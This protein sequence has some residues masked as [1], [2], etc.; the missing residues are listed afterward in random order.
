MKREVNR[1][2]IE[3][4]QRQIHALETTHTPPEPLLGIGLGALESAFPDQVFPRG[5]IHELIST[6]SEEATCTSGFMA[7]LLEKFLKQGGFCLWISTKPRRSIF[8]PALKVFGVEPDRI[9]F[10]DAARPK[11]TLWVLEEALKCDALTA[12]VG[13]L[14]ELSFN[15]S[16][17]LQLAVER[18]HVTGFI[19]RFQ[20]KTQNSVACVSRWKIT[21]IASTTPNGMPGVGFPAWNVELLKVKNGQPGKWQV[22]WSPKGLEY[23]DRETTAIPETYERQIG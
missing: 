9:L 6:S 1:K 5:V 20:P 2:I 15:E 4:L 16:R 10:V 19:H 7:I 17:R 12:V 14:T 13:E 21:P 22:Q 3:Q 23:I 8:P 18:S 11:E